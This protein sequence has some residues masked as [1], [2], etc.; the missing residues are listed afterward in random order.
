MPVAGSSGLL[1]PALT[2][3]VPNCSGSVSRPSVSIGNWNG[4]PREAGGWPICPAGASRFSLRIALATSMAVMLRDAS[5]CGSSQA[6]M[7]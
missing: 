4:W 6:R 3:I 1:G 7:L 5:F 2:T